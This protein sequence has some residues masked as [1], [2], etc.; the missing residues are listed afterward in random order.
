VHFGYDDAVP[1]RSTLALGFHMTDWL[2]DSLLRHGWR[3]VIGLSLACAVGALFCPAYP[4]NVKLC[5]ILAL[6]ATTPIA[7]GFFRLYLKAVTSTD[8]NWLGPIPIW[9]T[10]LVM[11]LGAAA[12]PLSV[13]LLPFYW[14]QVPTNGVGFALFVGGLPNGFGVAIAAARTLNEYRLLA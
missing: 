14:K 10:I 12:L 13:I 8:R 5:T 9:Y 6:A 11:Y 3:V 2:V 4:A 1:R 7:Y